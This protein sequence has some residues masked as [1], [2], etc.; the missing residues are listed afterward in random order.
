MHRYFRLWATIGIALAALIG[1]WLVVTWPRLKGTVEVHG[2]LPERG[3]LQR[4]APVYYQGVEVGRVANVSPTNRGDTVVV[5]LKLQAVPPVPLSNRSRLQRRRLGPLG[6]DV[7]DLHD[8]TAGDLNSGV[9]ALE[10]TDTL[11]GL[12]P[13]PLSAGSIA[14]QRA[15]DSVSAMFERGRKRAP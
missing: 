3:R 15:L 4:D 5:R 12:A 13:A 1:S 10:P 11:A 14:A 2:W 9:R 6:A 8:M 7:V